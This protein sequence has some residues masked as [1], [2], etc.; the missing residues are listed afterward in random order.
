MKVQNLMVSMYEQADKNIQIQ[1]L[2]NVVPQYKQ[3]LTHDIYL[4]RGFQ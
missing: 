4:A 1:K 3:M 2:L